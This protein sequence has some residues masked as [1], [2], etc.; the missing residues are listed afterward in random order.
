MKRLLKASKRHPEASAAALECSAASPTFGFTF[1]NNSQGASAAA[2]ELSTALGTAL[3]QID[4][5]GDLGD[6]FKHLVDQLDQEASN[7]E[8]SKIGK[9]DTFN[10]WECRQGTA[11]LLSIAWKCALWSYDPAGDML[12]TEYCRFRKDHV[13]SASI[14]GTVKALSCTVVE[15]L[16]GRGTLN[17][18]LPVLVIAVRGSASK[19]DHMVNANG[20]PRDANGFIDPSISGHHDLLAHSGFLNSAEALE[21]I[22]SQSISRYAQK[23]TSGDIRVL[24][25]GHSAGGA[26]ASLLYLHYLSREDLRSSIRFSCITFGAPPSITAEVKSPGCNRLSSNNESLCLNIINEFDLVSRAD[27]PYIL[28]IV[29]IFRSMYGQ[30]PLLPSDTNLGCDIPSQ[31][32]TAPPPSEPDSAARTFSHK[33]YLEN[34]KSAAFAAKIWPV[35]R[36]LYYHVGKKVVLLMRLEEDDVQMKA[37]QIL[38]PAFEKLLF[39]R[40]A[41]HSK[42]CYS[43]RIQLIE[44]GRFNGYDS[45]ERRPH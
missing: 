8:N 10:I 30:P 6:R 43:E 27:P 32:P 1:S 9:E 23:H 5:D 25:T 44:K 31:H 42:I 11:H 7:Y 45:W 21:S 41:V 28:S 35:P 19:M 2:A 39:C 18:F 4:L 37:V 40:V 22:V 24:F 15:P 29:N 12:D 34:E 3:D 36:P 17:T 33:A 16:S 13:A 38:T 20:R 14:G 26:V